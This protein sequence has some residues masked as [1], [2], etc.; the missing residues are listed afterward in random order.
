MTIPKAVETLIMSPDMAG[1]L[2]TPEEFD[3]AELDPDDA[4][5]Y[6]L[7]HSSR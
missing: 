5:R 1:A 2:M 6:E 3:L 4:S 7:I